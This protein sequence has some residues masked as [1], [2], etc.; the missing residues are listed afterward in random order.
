MGDEYRLNG[1]KP[2]KMP[3]GYDE[4]LIYSINRVVVLS[5]SLMIC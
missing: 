3:Q 5:R 2:T 1:L 4:M